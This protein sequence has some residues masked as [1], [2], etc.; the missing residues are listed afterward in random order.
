[1]AIKAHL[2]QPAADGVER[3]TSQDPRRTDRRALRFAT[4]GTFGATGE[5]NVTIHN[6]S[7]AGLLLETELA[8]AEGEGLTLDLPQAGVVTAVVVWRSDQLYGCAFEQAISP[9]GL[10]AVQLQ[11]VSVDEPA[12]PA[13][14]PPSIAS[15]EALGSRINRLRREAGLTLADVAAVLGVSKPT[16]WAWE[17]GKA[18]PLPERLDAIAATLNVAPDV[19]LSSPNETG[20]IETIITACRERIAEACEISP[21][22][23]KIMIEL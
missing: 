17:K 6:I 2:D 13:R 21:A 4:S 10:A 14:T 16:V 22:A 19:L 7:A 1:M 23:V 11:G 18:R 3:S 20:D 9:A 5:A 12:K 8:L 15:G